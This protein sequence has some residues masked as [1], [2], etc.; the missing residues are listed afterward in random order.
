MNPILRVLGFGLLESLASRLSPAAAVVVQFVLI[1]GGSLLPIVP[2]LTGAIHLADLLAY[3]VVGM[4]LS[5]AGTLIRLRTMTKQ[6]DTTTFLML[7]Y[8]IMIGILCVVCGVWA[9]I[10][11]AK[12]GPSGGWM[13]LWPM[14]IALVLA[15]AW[16]L[17]DGWFTRGGRHV[18]TVGQVVL[19]GYLRFGP[20]L[21]ATVLGAVAYIGESSDGTRVAIAVG[22]VLVQTVIDLGMAWWAVRLHSRV[23]A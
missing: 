1:I 17:A 18:V 10:L 6:S 7:H 11:L 9:G 12:A 19:P 4:A 23:A 5:I 13:A 20:L 14:V 21:V 22:L 15:Q 3:T 8:S 16:S 2:L